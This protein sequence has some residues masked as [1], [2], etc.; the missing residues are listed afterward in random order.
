MI[1]PPCKTVCKA[2]LRLRNRGGEIE[3]KLVGHTNKGRKAVT[4][5]LFGEIGFPQAHDHAGVWPAV[6]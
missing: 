5:L 6:N 4:K 1:R 3:V 2:G